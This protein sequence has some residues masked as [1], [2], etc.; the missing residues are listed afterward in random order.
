MSFRGILAVE[1][2]AAAATEF[3]ISMKLTND[4]EKRNVKRINIQVSDTPTASSVN[5]HDHDHT[6]P[7]TS[8]DVAPRREQGSGRSLLF[9]GLRER[10]TWYTFSFCCSSQP[11]G[12]A[13]GNKKTL[14]PFWEHL[15]LLQRTRDAVRMPV[16]TL[17]CLNT[18]RTL[19]SWNDSDWNRRLKTMDITPLTQI[20]LYLPLCL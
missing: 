17:N 12:T 8:N 20:L 16:T 11:L 2:A 19:S 14:P 13:G 4:A 10:P 18:K 3:S 7:S 6:S 5:V 15:C 1:D 9:D